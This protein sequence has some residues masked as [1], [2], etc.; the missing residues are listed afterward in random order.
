MEL[1]LEE[2]IT[3]YHR[4]RQCEN[5]FKELTW[6][7]ELRVLPSGDF[8]LNAVYLRV[9]TPAYN[10]FVALRALMLPEPYKPLNLKTFP[11]RLWGCPRWSFTTPDGN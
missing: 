6:D 8:F 9:I 5:R 3:S 4:H 7:F 10:L 1:P 2:H 11:L